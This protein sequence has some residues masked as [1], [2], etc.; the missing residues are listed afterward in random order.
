LAV[1]RSIGNPRSVPPVPGLDALDALTVTTD[2]GDYEATAYLLQVDTELPEEIGLERV[3]LAALGFE[4]KP[5]QT[6]V[7]PVAGATP[8][9]AVGLGDTAPPTLSALRDAAATAVRAVKNAASVRIVAPFAAEDPEAAVGALVEGAALARYR[10]TALKR[11][12]QH[13]ALTTVSVD[14]HGADAQ[15]VERAA[16]RARISA[17]ATVVARDLANTPPGHLTA[18]DLGVVAEQLGTR[19]GFDVELFDKKALL[20]LGC[21]G[22]LGVNQG[23]AEEPR[24]IKLTY[25]PQNES[26]AHIG[27]VG[28]GIMYDS[29][30]ISLKPSDPM[31]LLMKMDMAGAAAVLGAFTALKDYGVTSRATAWLM[32]TDNMPSGSALKLGDVLT[33]YNGTTVEIKNTDAEGRLVMCDAL[34]LAQEER[35][36]AIVDIATLTGA[37]LMALGTARAAL[38][39]NDDRVAQM[40]LAASE[41]VDEPLWRMPLERKYRAQLDSE[42]ADLANLGGKFAGATTAALFLEHFVGDT[43]WAH[44]D[45]AGTMNAEKDDAWR[46]SGATGYGARLLLE[47]ASTYVAA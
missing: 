2:P 7:I 45:I 32:C 10:Y 18:T 41:A 8:V 35:L 24:M 26:D 25:V 43:P 37:A 29:G 1:T 5:G 28:K 38:F 17:R 12:P 14:V 44:I 27:M 36:D 13:T 33:A 34:A 6:L 30:G 11:D 39:A 40:A 47:F 9:V 16:G 21:G 20:K 31:H 4:S 19:Y 3:A 15:V 23:S 22:L 42:I 46:T